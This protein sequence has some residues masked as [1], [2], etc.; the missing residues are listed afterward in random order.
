MTQPTRSLALVIHFHQPVGNLDSVVRK[1]TDRCYRPFLEVLEQH[2]AIP[3][4][5][6]YSGC[7]LEW[8]EEN[9]PDVTRTLR[10]LTERG[11]VE[12][13]TGGF[14]E[15]VLA[16]L[17]RAD[18]VGQIEMLSRHLRDRYAAEPTG[19]WLTERVWE[20]DVAPA[21]VDAGVRYTVLDD[22]MFH[23]VG[24]TDEELTGPF[25]TEHDGRPLL[26]YA[27][28]R[29]L[30]YLIPYKRVERVIHYLEGGE[31]NRLF[32]YA[33]DGEKFGEWPDTYERV[34]EKGWLNDFLGALGEQAE[35]LQLTTL[36]N[37]ASTAVPRGRV[38]L[39][40]SSYDEMMTWA[41]PSD[42]RLTLGKV[43]RELQK[44]DPRGLLPF[45]RGA[46]WRAFFAKYP[47]V[48]HL[49]KRMLHVSS[50]LHAADSPPDA[51]VKELYRAQCNCAYWHGAF[52]GVYLSFMRGAL[53]HH[54]LRAE[55]MIQGL[56]AG[57]AVEEVDIDA[58]ARNEVLVSAPWG[59]AV[60]SPAEGGTLVELD[61]WR[62]GA[63]LLAVVARHRE[64]YHVE[65]ENPVS[66]DDE[67]DE[68]EAIQARA[69]VDRDS[70]VFDDRARGALVDIVD[71]DRID[72]PFEYAIADGGSLHMWTTTNGLR[73]E[74]IALADADEL[75]T[76]YRLTRVGD[77]AAKVFAMEASVMPL[78]LGRSVDADEVV[79]TDRGWK[80]SHAE[81]EVGIEV[82]VSVPG[83]VKSQ[84]IET[85]SATLEGL[86]TMHQGT[87]VTM[88]WPLELDRGESFDVELRWRP[89]VNDKALTKT[90]RGVSS[91]V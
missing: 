50:A 32:V 58:D 73:I 83:N 26:V 49:Q 61:D 42:A 52:G 60:F 66:D 62:G 7:L 72:G 3:M 24:V 39:P 55:S 63:N 77:R 10:N 29:Q 30:R 89:V 69:D 34:Y 91:G 11:Q 23:S 8:L 4:T 41:L 2:P 59:R 12:L 81:A 87:A 6:H 37:H 82:D 67:D 47:E 35:W 36:G 15:P 17:P 86:E 22:T 5:L 57:P 16:A 21:L 20:Q 78:V 40:S 1:A 46:P 84:P 56:A 28:D 33:D 68:M 9:A 27:G 14:Y 64:A 85:A 18:Q 44:E 53:W 65:D 38:Y 79:I 75:I 45:L 80:V 88:E 25:V 71:G 51:A 43:R 54:L 76:T 70:L 90:E 31:G 19:L 74:K 13:M 48:N